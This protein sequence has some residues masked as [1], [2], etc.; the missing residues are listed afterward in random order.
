[1]TAVA[2]AKPVRNTVFLP[3]RME[4]GFEQSTPTMVSTIPL[5]L[6]KPKPTPPALEP[7]GATSRPNHPRM[8]FHQEAALAAGAPKPTA[9][10]N[11]SNRPRSTK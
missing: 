1:V 3:K 5:M 9:W 6:K 7:S 4:S 11:S 10:R 8:V 2:A